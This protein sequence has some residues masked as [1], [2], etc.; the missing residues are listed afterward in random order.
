M[1]TAP[2]PSPKFQRQFPCS[3]CGADLVFAP[4]TNCLKCPYCGA[5]NRL[6][7]ASPDAVQEEDFRATLDHLAGEAET[8]DALTV[9]CVAC[10]AE[11]QFGSDVVASKCPFCGAAIVATAESKKRI[12]PKAVLPFHI[13]RE[14]AVN[15]FR[16]WTGSLWFAPSELSKAAEQS[17]MDGVYIPAW[18]YDSDT[19]SRYSGQR[20]DD[21]WDT[22][23]YTTTDAN[24]NAVIRTRQVRRTRW[25]WVSGEVTNPFDDIL[26]LASRS[27]PRKFADAL[28]PWDLKNLVPYRDEYLSGFAAQSYQVDLPQGFDVAKGIMEGYIRQ[29]VCRDIGGDHQRIDSLQTRYDNITFKHT[30][31]PVWISAYRYRERVFQFLVN[32]R[33]GEVQGERPYSVWKIV[34]LI[35]AILLIVVGGI[36]IAHSR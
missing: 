17:K 23:T 13:T 26:V 29:S 24:G 4:G 9:K 28:E 18:T 35:F 22:E 12:K 20:G 21:Y 27:L 2:P 7:E 25:T 34:L 31:L 30:L 32:A 1:D 10:G 15:A 11:S 36:L 33:T 8:T 16:Q 3:N 14:Q 5:E 6:P 19:D